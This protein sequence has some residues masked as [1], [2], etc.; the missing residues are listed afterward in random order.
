MSNT[1]NCAH[2]YISTPSNRPFNNNVHLQVGRGKNSFHTIPL[3]PHLDQKGPFFSLEGVTLQHNGN[4]PQPNLP[5]NPSECHC[6]WF[7]KDIFSLLRS[8]L[9]MI[10]LPAPCLHDDK[11]R[12]SFEEF[13]LM[14]KQ[15]FSIALR[16]IKKNLTIRNIH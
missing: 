11:G 10:Y 15:N 5:I 1:L 9:D 3:A 16:R 4:W 7:L 6:S 8:K 13:V 2:H 14:L 12:S